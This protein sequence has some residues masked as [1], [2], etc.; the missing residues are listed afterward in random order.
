MFKNIFNSFSESFKQKTTNPLLGTYI[1]VWMLRNWEL[2]YSIFNFDKEYKLYQKIAFIKEY[3]HDKSF[4]NEILVSLGLTFLTLIVT[5]LLLNLSRLIVNF[6]E[7]RITPF[8]Y[9]ITDSTSIV[10]KSLFEDVRNERDEIQ[11]RLDAERETRSRLE[12]R[13]KSLEDELLDKANDI[14]MN[15]SQPFNKLDE[16][17][18]IVEK[19]KQ[20]ELLEKY[21]NISVRI[22]RG[23]M[24]QSNEE[25][26]LERFL[27]LGLISIFKRNNIGIQYNL[28]EKGEAVLT[29]ASLL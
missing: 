14:T 19:L 29:N 10:T 4:I 2:I 23:V 8:I 3:F 12:K 26:E 11:N 28:S 6:S 22:K 15:S 16:T 5:Y 13:I 25:I 21:K 27:Q 24:F 9:K 20:E 1:L 17:T 18:R 7:K